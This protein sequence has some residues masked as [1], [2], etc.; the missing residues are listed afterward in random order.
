L[1]YG[2]H[3]SVLDRCSLQMF[4]H[5][6]YTLSAD[7]QHSLFLICLQKQEGIRIMQDSIIFLEIYVVLL[8]VQ[9]VAYC[10]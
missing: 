7:F 2:A 3:C 6:P 9:K 5:A 1:I 4:R 10:T 8:T